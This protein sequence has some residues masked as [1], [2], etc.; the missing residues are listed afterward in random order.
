MESFIVDER[1]VNGGVQKIYKFDTDMERPLSNIFSH[2]EEHK[3]CG[4]WLC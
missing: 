2:T 3:V 4:K 1:S